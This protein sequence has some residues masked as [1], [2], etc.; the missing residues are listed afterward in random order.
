VHLS[1]VGVSQ[2]VESDLLSIVLDLKH[3]Q[4]S[5]GLSS[6]EAELSEGKRVLSAGFK[7][8]GMVLANLF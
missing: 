3:I 8:D 2:L 1:T 4:K 6:M 7:Q 5:V